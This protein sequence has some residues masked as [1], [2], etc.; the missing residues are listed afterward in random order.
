MKIL[1]ICVCLKCV[2]EGK[3]V[4]VI[5]VFDLRKNWG[6]FMLNYVSVNK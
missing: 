1:L 2:E 6:F 4:K 3:Y 5:W